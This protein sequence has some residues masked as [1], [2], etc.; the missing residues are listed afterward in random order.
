MTRSLAH[1][2]YMWQ[3]EPRGFAGGTNSFGHVIRQEATYGSPTGNGIEGRRVELGC[4]HGVSNS[5]A[6]M[7][8]RRPVTEESLW[9]VGRA[10]SDASPDNSPTLQAAL[11][12]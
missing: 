5:A 9:R 12:D 3:L 2:K 8:L 10:F 11:E 1:T 7:A 6:F 4:N